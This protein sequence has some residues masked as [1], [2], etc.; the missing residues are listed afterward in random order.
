MIAN[1]VNRVSVL[2]TEYRKVLEQKTLIMKKAIECITKLD[3]IKC[4]LDISLPL[5]TM[6]EI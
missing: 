1:I 6:S 4:P 3:R 5:E 2:V